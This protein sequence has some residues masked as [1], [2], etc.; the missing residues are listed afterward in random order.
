MTDLFNLYITD[1]RWAH[2]DCSTSETWFD[3]CTFDSLL[4]TSTFVRDPQKN[5]RCLVGCAEETVPEKPWINISD[6]E[7]QFADTHLRYHKNKV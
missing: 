3:A 7:R 1:H 4:E 5:L 6:L 2:V